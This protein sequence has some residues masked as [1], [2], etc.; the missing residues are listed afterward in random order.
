MVQRNTGFT[1]LQDILY[2]K[3]HDLKAGSGVKHHYNQMIKSCTTCGGPVHLFLSETIIYTEDFCTKLCERWGS[4]Y[5][6][7]ESITG[8]CKSPEDVRNRLLAY[9]SYMD[10]PTRERVRLLENAWYEE[11]ENRREWI[12]QANIIYREHRKRTLVLERE[13]YVKE[14]TRQKKYVSE[15][16]SIEGF[17][18]RRFNEPSYTDPVYH[19][20]IQFPY[21]IFEDPEVSYSKSQ[22][23]QRNNP[24]CPMGYIHSE[25]VF[26][27]DPLHCESVHS[28]AVARGQVRMPSG[29][30]ELSDMFT[31]TNKMFTST[32]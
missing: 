13:H 31:T 32:Y 15:N 18:I 11:R 20:A 14:E 22:T 16:G 17:T 24:V 30:N 28:M 25:A 19:P 23:F 12:E 7:R 2:N 9:F 29:C 10:Q 3:N 27:G 1:T 26:G 8:E 6:D 21:S 5:V 4:Q